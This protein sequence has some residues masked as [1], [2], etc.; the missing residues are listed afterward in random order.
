MQQ[1]RK[2]SDLHR[3]PIGIIRGEIDCPPVEH[4]ILFFRFHLKRPHSY[5]CNGECEI[6]YFQSIDAQ[7][8]YKWWWNLKKRGLRE[9]KI[10]EIILEKKYFETKIFI[11]IYNTIDQSVTIF[12]SLVFLGRNREKDSNNGYYSLGSNEKVCACAF[13]IDSK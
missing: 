10:L 2:V 9:K 1:G 11:K 8:Y 5:A 3:G 12:A 7:L 4:S 13:D 6:D